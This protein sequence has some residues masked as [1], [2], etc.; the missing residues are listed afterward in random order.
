MRTTSARLLIIA[1]LAMMTITMSAQDN[2]RQRKSREELAQIQARRISDDLAL[3]DK[4]SARFI[5]TYC[6]C[7]REV[8]ALGPRLKGRKGQNAR[9]RGNSVSGQTVEQRFECSQKLLDI[10]KKYY[11]EYS[12]FL[13]EKQIERVYSLEK[14]TMSRLARRSQQKAGRR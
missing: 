5:E 11:A 12:K 6:Q 10:R 2:T 9:T 14:Q 7:Q 4:T 8:W 1:L 13:T 3:D